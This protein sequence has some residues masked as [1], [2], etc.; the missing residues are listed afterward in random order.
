MGA[1]GTSKDMTQ[2]RILPTLVLFSLPL[3]LSGL[4]Q[5]LY[6]WAD[7]LIV[8]NILGE[9]ALAAVGATGTVSGTLLSL[10]AGFS[11]GV[12]IMVAQAYG[13]NDR[14][15]V[16]KAAS[17]FILL[18]GLAS[19]LLML[20]GLLVARPALQLLNTPADIIDSAAVYLRIILL[21]L[22]FMAVYNVYYAVLRG[23]GDSR[24]PLLAIIVSSATNV[25][26]D[27][28]FVASFGWGV[29]GAA[30]ATILAQ[31][32]MT[33]FVA[34]YCRFRHQSLK[35]D[36]SRRSFDR[37]VLK[38][39][40]SLSIPTAVQ[41]A[42]RSTG[43]MMLQNVMNSFGTQT[44][45]AVTTAYRIDTI[46][47]L[48]VINLGAGITTFTAQN[49]GAGQ[50]QRTRRGLWLGSILSALTALSIT[51]IILFVG[52]PLLALFGIS[53]EAVQIGQSVLM[54]LAAFYPLFG[55]MSA[56]TGY[57]QGMGDVSFAGIIS[58]LALFLRVGASYLLAPYFGSMVIAYAE[59]IAWLFQTL[60][61]LGRYLI[62]FHVRGGG[63]AVEME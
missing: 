44:L 1:D 40:L 22:P 60:A 52:E 29:A 31:I 7:A 28:L 32:M 49:E 45:A 4:L 14:A 24:T 46:G 17:L 25:V 21:G 53:P 39:G 58:I 47:M 61:C 26:L 8:G 38:T 56:L 41:A 19:L 11:V 62:K 36:F 30:Y 57:L 20:L 5:Q 13:R 43:G 35:L 33:L 16:G 10:V 27:L 23:I 12:S 63:E 51:A 2:G 3:M 50:R 34:L 15:V 18:S 37:E 9:G 6:S 55:I 42:I 54:G 59:I 48:P